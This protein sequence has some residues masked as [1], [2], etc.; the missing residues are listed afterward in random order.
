MSGGPL[1]RTRLDFYTRTKYTK[2]LDSPVDLDSAKEFHY[3]FQWPVQPASPD[4]SSIPRG[5]R[6]HPFINSASDKEKIFLE[7]RHR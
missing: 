5:L 4:I 6:I 2:H 7:S 1:V 3:F